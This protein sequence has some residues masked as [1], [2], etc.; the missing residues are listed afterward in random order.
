MVLKGLIP[1]C[2][3]G[4]SCHMHH[5][6]PPQRCPLVSHPGVRGGWDPRGVQEEGGGVFKQLRHGPRWPHALTS[7]VG[8]SPLPGAEARGKRGCESH[9]PGEGQRGEEPRTH[10]GTVG[11]TPEPPPGQPQPGAL[12]RPQGPAAGA[13]PG[14]G[15]ARELWV[16]CKDTALSPPLQAR[17]VPPRPQRGQGTQGTGTNRA[18]EGIL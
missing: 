17:P 9:N 18:R 6:H 10:P 5:G 2:G 14:V 7:R 8:G 13:V 3:C 15:T 11:V 12:A 1:S 4:Q 16:T